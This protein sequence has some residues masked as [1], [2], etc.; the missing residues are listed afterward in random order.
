VTPERERRV[1][2]TGHFKE[3]PKIIVLCGYKPGIGKWLRDKRWLDDPE[4]KGDWN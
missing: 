3:M 2:T 1:L 4:K